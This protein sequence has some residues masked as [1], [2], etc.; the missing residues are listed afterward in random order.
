MFCCPGGIGRGLALGRKV[1]PCQLGKLPVFITVCAKNK[2]PVVT[3]ATQ[4]GALLKAISQ[5]LF[6]VFFIDSQEPSRTPSPH[7]S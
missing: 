1:S 5:R 3:T 2:A 6:I 4:Q 7:H